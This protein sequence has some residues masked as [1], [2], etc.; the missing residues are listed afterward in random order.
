[1]ISRKLLS[2]TERSDHSEGNYSVSNYGYGKDFI[3]ILHVH[4]NGLVHTVTEFEVST[5]LKLSTRMDWLRGMLY[6]LS[7][8]CYSYVFVLQAYIWE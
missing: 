7:L 3:K 8:L 4:R 1:M 2:E 5:H 6:I